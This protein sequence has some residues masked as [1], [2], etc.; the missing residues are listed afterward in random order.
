MLTLAQNL[1][2]K[3]VAGR[4]TSNK[5]HNVQD[6]SFLKGPRNT[7]Q[8]KRKFSTQY[9]LN[10]VVLYPLLRREMNTNHNTNAIFTQFHIPFPA[11]FYYKRNNSSNGTGGNTFHSV[12]D[13]SHPFS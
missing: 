8:K 9:K 6:F 3:F 12:N 10:E 4:C 5:T 7:T 2:S 13:K 11:E 1:I